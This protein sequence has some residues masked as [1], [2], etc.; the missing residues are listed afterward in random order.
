MADTGVPDDEARMIV[1]RRTRIGFPRPRR[2]IWVNRC[3]S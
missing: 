3:P 2:T 1:A